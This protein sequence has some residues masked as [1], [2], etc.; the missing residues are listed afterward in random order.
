MKHVI[1]LVNKKK[2]NYTKFYAERYAI[3]P[4]HV[5]NGSYSVREVNLGIRS[6]G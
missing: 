6:E 5:S 2:Y 4:D 1:S 3:C